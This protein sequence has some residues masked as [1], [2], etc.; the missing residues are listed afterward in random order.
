MNQNK[1]INRFLGSSLFCILVLAIAYWYLGIGD[2]LQSR[3]VSVHMWAMCDRGSVARNYAQSSMNFFLPRT[4]YTNEGEGIT[5][6]EFPL[7]N[8]LAAICY[9]VFGFSEF[10]YRFL[11]LLTVTMGLVS[12]WNIS[13]RF[14]NPG[15]SLIPPLVLL[16]CPI[17][18]Y[19][20]ASFLPDAASLGFILTGWLF[21][22]RANG[23]FTR[24]DLVLITIFFS[25]AA[26]IKITALI[27]VV[28]LLLLN[29]ISLFA[30]D[31]KFP[32]FRESSKLIIPS[33]IV[34]I[35]TIS[36]Y[37]YAS[38]L[39]AT[40]KSEVFLM[41]LMPPR[42]FEY[43]SV[44]FEEIRKNWG[45]FYYHPGLLLY[46]ILSLL[47]IPVLYNK[48]DKHL[49]FI[50][51]SYWAGN[52]CFFIIMMEQFVHHDY[53]IL[54]LLP[55]VFFQTLLLLDAAVK[56][57]WLRWVPLMLVVILLVGFKFDREHQQFRYTEDCWLFNWSKYKDYMDAEAYSRTL[58]I[59]PEDKII[60]ICD[61]S[62]NIPLYLLN[63][64]GWRLHPRR[65]EELTSILQFQPKYVICSDSL[66]IK[67]PSLAGRLSRI[68]TKGSIEYYRIRY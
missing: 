22:F 7:M 49:L 52:V 4:N 1:S 44:I 34:F 11:M 30:K 2:A 13:R 37:K 6:L 18:T 39:S 12:A 3:P 40:H 46:V 61:D 57:S 21:Y 43:I 32:R 29:V 5:G 25:I 14:L 62:Y 67:Q 15:V 64:R 45:E 23:K 27:S 58:G 9:K 20:A 31:E 42:S 60:S 10:W 35:V 54:T 56:F 36:W 65:E 17:L 19:Y 51:Y 68:G 63:Q 55:A 53:Y 47:L 38:W 41:Q 16:A 66:R 50:T 8:Y 59:Q 26:L 33:V 48:L 28:V 24:K